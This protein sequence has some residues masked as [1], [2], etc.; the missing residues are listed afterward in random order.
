MPAVRED[1]ARDLITSV[2]RKIDPDKLSAAVRQVLVAP[3][4]Y[5]AQ[6][7]LT[8]TPLFIQLMVTC[9]GKTFFGTAGGFGSIGQAGFAGEVYT[10][11]L[12]RLQSTT[13]AFQFTLSQL[14]VAINFFDANQDYLGFFLADVSTTWLGTGG[15][16]GSWS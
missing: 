7:T 9:E 1:I 16:A 15:G 6:G 8:S 14:Y 11:D 2:G 13:V 5:P 3:Y 4:K 10:D 12:H